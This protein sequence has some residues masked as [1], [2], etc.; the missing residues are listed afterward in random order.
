MTSLLARWRGKLREFG[1]AQDGNIA[2]TFAAFSFPMIFFLGWAIDYSIGNSAKA[3]MQAALDATGL[4]LSKEAQKLNNGEAL[5][6]KALKYFLA[7]FNRPDV[8]NV[9]IT[10]IFTD[11]NN[12]KYKLE[13]SATGQVP[14]SLTGMWKDHMNIGSETQV[15]WGYKK[16]ELALALDNTGSMSSNK[17]MDQLKTAAKNLIDTLKKAAKSNGDIRI[18]IVP[19]ATDVNIGTGNV[20]ADWIRWD[21]WEAEP[22]ALVSSKP[23]NWLDI[24]AGSNCPFTNSNPYRFKCLQGPNNSSTVSKIPSSGLICPSPNNDGTVYNGCYD[25]KNPITE[26]VARGRNASCGGLSNCSCSGSGNNKVCTQKTGFPWVVNNHSTWNGCVWDR[27]QD[28]DVKNT[29]A[30]KNIKST[31]FSTHQA[32]NCPVTMLPLT[33][34]WNALTS[35]INAMAPTGNTNV[36]I[37]MAVAF[38]TLSPVAPFN[39]SAPAIDLDKVII[40]LTDGEN[41]ESRFSSSANTIDKRTKLACDNAK[42]AN[43]KVYTIRVINGNSSLLQQCASKSDMYYD[44]QEASQLNTVFVTIANSLASLRLAQ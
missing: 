12:G 42:A 17:K 25:S 5:N 2:I 4:S 39:A 10:P 29:A 34:D 31:R 3:S 23:G 19:F 15:I 18:S 30:D 35:K 24:E 37:G 11:L 20:N 43:I 21:E 32:S 6:A 40:L 27:D 41:T 26:E 9:T 16:L 33:Y 8:Q 7:N 13:L 22:A 14:T 38:Q 36:T 1:P 44:V 28:N